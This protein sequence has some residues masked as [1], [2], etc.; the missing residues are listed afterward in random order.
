LYEKTLPKDLSWR[1]RLNLTQQ[2]G[3]DILELWTEEFPD[4]LELV[5]EAGQFIRN[6]M[7]EGWDRHKSRNS[8]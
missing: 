8:A 7:K 4:A 5:K 6:R 2:T 3:F 1:E